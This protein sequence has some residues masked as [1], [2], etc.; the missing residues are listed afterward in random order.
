MRGRCR[1]DLPGVVEVVVRCGGGRELV[2]FITPHRRRN[3]MH[4]LSPAAL[5]HKGRGRHKALHLL[6]LTRIKRVRACVGSPS[7]LVGE[8]CRWKAWRIALAGE[9]LWRWAPT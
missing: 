4:V 9:G 6:W 7:P 1:G 5:S 8:G 2:R 3:R